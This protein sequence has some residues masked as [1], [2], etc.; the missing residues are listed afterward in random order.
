MPCTRI[1]R[2]CQLSPASSPVGAMASRELAADGT[3]TPRPVW[4]VWLDERLLLSVGSTSHWRGIGAKP[5]VAVHLGDPLSVVILQGRVSKLKEEDVFHQY[6]EVFNTRYSWNFEPANP[7]VADG[8]L[9]VLPSVVLAWNTIPAPEYDVPECRRPL[10]VRLGA[11][12]VRL[13]IV[14]RPI[15]GSG[16]VQRPT[17]RASNIAMLAELDC[18]DI[19]A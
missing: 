16:S 5:E 9:E 19:G 13:K 12:G 11:E 10:D 3:P 4:G 14:V 15:D 17:E 6:V 18:A 1:V 7:M 8:T 2:F